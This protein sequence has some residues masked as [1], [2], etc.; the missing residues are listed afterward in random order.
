MS[1]S[2]V[3]RIAN[4]DDFKVEEG[5]LHPIKSLMLLEGQ[6][7]TNSELGN[8]LAVARDVL[9]NAQFYV[10]D[11]WKANFGGFAAIAVGFKGDT[12]IAGY[13]KTRYSPDGS[14]RLPVVASPHITNKRYK[15]T[16]T[17]WFEASSSDPERLAWILRKYVRPIY[18][19]EALC[20]EANYLGEFRGTTATGRYKLTSLWRELGVSQTGSTEVGLMDRAKELLVRTVNTYRDEYRDVACLVDRIAAQ[21]RAL[22]N[23]LALRHGVMVIS[24]DPDVH[25]KPIAMGQVD[26]RAPA[27]AYTCDSAEYRKFMDSMQY[28]DSIDDLPDIV[29][30]RLALLGMAKERT[31]VE[32]VGI[33]NYDIAFVYTDEAAEDFGDE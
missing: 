11:Q 31:F 16:S 24:L 23:T 2:L 21:Q 19:H 4:L 29:S 27:W 1:A 28:F 22:I 13:L 10:T 9:P 17:Q 7:I 33:R 20:L 30:G 6:E 8:L 12:H 3:D 5:V 25:P 18:V 32:G 26:Y 15:P 14:S